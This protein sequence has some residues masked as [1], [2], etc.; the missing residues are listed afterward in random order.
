MI[1]LVKNKL[2]LPILIKDR[3]FEFF[4]NFNIIIKLIFLFNFLIYCPD[5]LIWNNDRFL[6]TEKILIQAVNSPKQRTN[7]KRYAFNAHNRCYKIKDKL[8]IPQWGVRHFKIIPLS[9]T[10][11]RLTRERV[12][13]CDQCVLYTTQHDYAIITYLSR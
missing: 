5:Y 9:S 7:R 8:N 3:N 6:N 1:D 10:R 4:F 12:T 2:I 11:T 13:N